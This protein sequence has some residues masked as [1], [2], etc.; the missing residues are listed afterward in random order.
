[1]GEPD[2]TGLDP[3]SGSA[4][5]SFML[6]A[7]M[8]DARN[9][10]RQ[11]AALII[12]A[13]GLFACT[14]GRH[15]SGRGTDEEPATGES[16]SGSTVT[17]PDSAAKPLSET[18]RLMLAEAGRACQSVGADG[19]VP[20]FDAFIRSEAVRRRYSAS[21]ISVSKPGTA[22]DGS[23]T[24]TVPVS[25]YRDFPVM[26]ED[27]YRRPARPSG[28]DEYIEVVFNQSASNRISV[29]WTRVRYTGTPGGG[30]DLGSPVTID[31]RPYDPEGEADG[32][33]LFAPTADCWELVADIRFRG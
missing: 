30:D 32:Q 28:P 4:G 21:E 11:C 3:L 31:G 18:D 8:T 5:V 15:D 9:N 20:F 26:M 6:A 23:V 7:G 16:A 12:A 22:G 24:S 17:S 29:E 19:Y 25:E 2:N 14:Q 33:L 1:M 10:A 27:H 13:C